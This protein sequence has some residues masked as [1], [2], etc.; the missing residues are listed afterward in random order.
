MRRNG[1]LR[2]F[3]VNLDTAVRFADPDFLS[4]CKILA[5][6]RRF[7]LIFA[8]FIYWM[9]AI[10]I[11]PVCLTYWPRKYTTRVDPTSLIPTKFEDDM[12]IHC[13]VTAFLYADTSRDLVTLTFKF[14]TLNSCHTWRVTWPTFVP[15]LKTLCLSGLELW[16]IMV[17]HWLPLQMRTRPLCMRRV[18]W[19][20][21]T[22]SK[23]I[24]FLE[25]TTPICLFPV[26]LRWLYDEC[27]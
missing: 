22:G 8:F 4:E 19:P 15:T 18:T 10:F 5:I 21:S 2:T 11:L 26:Q 23:T 17:S 13:R 7:P 16:V 27:N 14:L 6:W 1:Y 9:S 24:T 3:G 12:S 20:V 25:W